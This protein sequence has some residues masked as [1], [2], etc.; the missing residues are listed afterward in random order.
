LIKELKGERDEKVKPGPLADIGSG[1]LKGLAGIASDAAGEA[2]GLNPAQQE[3]EPPSKMVH[4]APG[5]KDVIAAIE[6]SLGKI[7]FKTKIRLM[8][9][10]PKD[11]FRKEVKSTIVGAFRQFDDI[12]LNGFK[13]DLR[14]T[15][16]GI[17]PK[18]FLPIERPFINFFVK[19]RKKRLVRFYKHRKFPFGQ[20][21][22]V[23]NI[24]E[25]ATIFH[26][27]LINVKAP[28]ITK[29]ETHRGEAP[30]NLPT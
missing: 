20:K 15:W 2:Q 24:E 10:A 8:Y 17:N 12:N 14:K 6:A 30:I 11:K 5:E 9:L 1:V 3:Y 7:G 26:F 18:V 28:Q 22:F 4:L 13:P 16:T 23:L 27:P 29:A 21:S 19:I 25:C